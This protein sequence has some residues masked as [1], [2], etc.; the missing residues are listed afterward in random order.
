[1][2]TLYA[3]ARLTDDLADEEQFDRDEAKQTCRWL[4]ECL[5]SPAL[6]IE[7]VPDQHLPLAGI[8]GRLFPAIHD[9]LNRFSMNREHM[10]DLVRG[11]E[12]D[13]NN[14]SII[15]T[16]EELF[17]YCRWVASSVGLACVEIWRGDVD[18]TKSAAIDCGMAFQL[19]NILRDVAEDARRNRVY[20]PLNSLGRFHCSRIAL[21]KRTPDG[22]WQ[23]LMRQYISL[24]KGLFDR[25]K[26]IFPYLPYDGQ[27]M[28]SLMWSSYRALLDEVEGN[29]DQVW[30]RRIRL[31]KTQ[32]AK[33][34]LQHAI[35]PLFAAHPMQQ[36]SR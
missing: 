23:E 11:A 14:E 34:Y 22:N 13:L 1:M 33:L 5:K 10:H 18:A 8:F 30:L 21:L 12:F 31:T 28:F 25:A 7:S 6:S 36:D 24:S 2:H 4:H 15:E 20:L 32:K 29:L 26:I 17:Q 35:S 3:F 16:D 9:M 19:T 27:R